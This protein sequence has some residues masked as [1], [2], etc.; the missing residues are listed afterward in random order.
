M[1]DSASSRVSG[2]TLNSVSSG[3]SGLYLLGLRRTSDVRRNE[4]IEATMDCIRAHVRLIFL[5]TMTVERSRYVLTDAILALPEDLSGHFG[6]LLRRLE[7]KLAQ[8]SET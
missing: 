6:G 3:V 5:V 7:S 2:S 8:W 4:L 1:S